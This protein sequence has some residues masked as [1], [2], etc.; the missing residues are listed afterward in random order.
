MYGFASASPLLGVMTLR[1]PASV[2][3]P[4]HFS[5]NSV[6]Q[7]DSVETD[8]FYNY[9]VIRTTSGTRGQKSSASAL[10]WARWRGIAGTESPQVRVRCVHANPEGYSAEHELTVPPKQQNWKPIPGDCLRN[11][12]VIKQVSRPGA[13]GSSGGAATASGGVVDQPLTC[14]SAAEEKSQAPSE[15]SSFGKTGYCTLPSWM[16][17]LFLE[18]APHEAIVLEFEPEKVKGEDNIKQLQVFPVRP[19]DYKVSIE[20]AQQHRAH[21][22]GHHDH[23]DTLD[24]DAEAVA[25]LPHAVAD[26]SN[27]VAVPVSLAL[28]VARVFEANFQSN[29]NA[30]FLSLKQGIEARGKSSNIL[31]TPASLLVHLRVSR[32]SSS[33]FADRNDA[34]NSEA[35]G[36]PQFS[37][38]APD[39]GNLWQILC[40]AQHSTRG[41]LKLRVN[42]AFALVIDKKVSETMTSVGNDQVAWLQQDLG[43]LV[44]AAVSSSQVIDTSENGGSHKVVQQWLDAM[45]SA[46]INKLVMET[47]GTGN[48][49]DPLASLPVD[50]MWEVEVQMMN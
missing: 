20:A 24:D 12:A 25:G 26:F 11:R 30:A 48:A 36:A 17:M 50:L 2:P 15:G 49:A 9:P 28:R 19:Y 34:S 16:V 43:S 31:N 3:Q 14:V 45:L 10:Q 5:V 6:L 23:P 18:L 39:L 22:E 32:R 37:W 29:G 38:S 7:L 46:Y 21:Q 8:G 1:N 42:A 27:L 4:A 44:A 41:Q 40:L 47:R 13:V 35:L 33:L